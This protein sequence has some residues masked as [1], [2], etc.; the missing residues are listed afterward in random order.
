MNAVH[1]NLQT[2]LTDHFSSQFSTLKRIAYSGANV[3]L[4]TIK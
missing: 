2:I 1:F 4:L 3:T